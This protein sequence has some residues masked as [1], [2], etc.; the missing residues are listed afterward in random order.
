MSD[1]DFFGATCWLGGGPTIV[2]SCYIEMDTGIKAGVEKIEKVIKFAAGRRLLIHGDFNSRMHEKL[3]DQRWTK[4]ER[5]FARWLEDAP[6]T[7]LNKS[8]QFTFVSANEQKKS[9]VD[10]TV[11]SPNFARQVATW[12]VSDEVTLSDP[13]YIQMS[14]TSGED[15]T[16]ERKQRFDMRNADWKRFEQ[17]LNTTHLPVPCSAEEIDFF[18]QH[19]ADLPTSACEAVS[20]RQKPLKRT[21]NW[22]NHRL[23]RMKKEVNHKKNRV[24]RTSADDAGILSQ[25]HSDYIL[26]R[27]RYKKEITRA[28]ERC[29]RRI[30]TETT[31]TNFWQTL[32]KLKKRESLPTALKLRSGKLC[33]DDR[34]FC[35][36]LLDAFFPASCPA[37]DLAAHHN[38]PANERTTLQDVGLIAKSVNDLK[39][40]KAPGPDGFSGEIVKKHYLYR[41]ESFDV[42]MQSYI[43]AGHFPSIWK[44]G[45]VIPVPK[46]VNDLTQSN[47][48]VMLAGHN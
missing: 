21:N 29:F 45:V 13:R 22:W 17:I 4:N 47:T 35:E 18:A 46:G 32:K 14:I 48:L 3:G 31:P 44:T 26:C 30:F 10:Y 28:K 1:A 15:R 2:V 9:I 43:K 7:L 42:L 25:L 41:K 34:L 27:N 5:V 38:I 40:K 16:D 20:G 33:G 37:F 39:N 12:R 23:E 6:V 11:A 24:R 8:D 36:E 19:E